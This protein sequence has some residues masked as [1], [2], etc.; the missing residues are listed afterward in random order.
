M[1]LLKCK[2][3]VIVLWMNNVLFFICALALFTAGLVSAAHAHVDVQSPDQ[4]IELSIDHSNT[5]GDA[6]DPLCDLHCGHSHVT[7]TDHTKT[8]FLEGSPKLF[9]MLS[10]NSLSSPIY[11][12][13]RPPR[14]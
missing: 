1:P 7:F 13:K 11:G 12:L 10:Q 14:I 4:Q 8:N 2:L 6:A 9:G 3:N 5:G